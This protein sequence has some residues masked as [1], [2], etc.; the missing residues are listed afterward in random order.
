MP[1]YHI[2]PPPPIEMEKS[3]IINFVLELNNI[4]KQIDNVNRALPYGPGN[5]VIKNRLSVALASCQNLISQI[6]I[7]YLT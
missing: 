2:S 5:I 1:D 3:E 7:N 4:H 6:N